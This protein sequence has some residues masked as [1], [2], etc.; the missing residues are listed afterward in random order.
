MAD[1]LVEV[2][3]S[4]VNSDTLCVSLR[5]E[6]TSKDLP[7]L[8]RELENWLSR[9]EYLHLQNGI[10][11][12]CMT[13]G[14]GKFVAEAASVATLVLSRHFDVVGLR[15]FDYHDRSNGFRIVHSTNTLYPVG[16]E[17]RA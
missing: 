9:Q 16:Y 13:G 2:H 15:I 14:E 17:W 11:L 8:T 6:C 10:I 4:H 12:I 1:K 5:S 3:S 7:D